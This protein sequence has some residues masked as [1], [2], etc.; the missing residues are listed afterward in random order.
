MVSLNGC[1]WLQQALN[2]APDITG[3]DQY[4]LD[5][6]TLIPEGGTI[7]EGTVVLQGIMSDPDGD[8]VKLQIEL[9]R[10]EEAFTSVPT[11]ESDWVASGVPAAWV[12]TDLANESYKWQYRA[13]DERGEASAWSE[14]GSPGNTDFVVRASTEEPTWVSQPKVLLVICNP[15]LEAD[16]GQTLVQYYGWNDPDLLAQQYI[17]DV[18]QC[19]HGQVQYRIVERFERDE[20]PL[21]TDGF[22][23]TDETYKIAWETRTMH[24]SIIDY[25]Y[26]LKQHDV[27]RKVE[28]GEVDEV[29]IVGFPWGWCWES[30]M[31]GDGAIWINGPEVDYSC[32]RPF[33][34]MGFNYERGVDCMLENLGHRAECV[35]HYVYDGPGWW[36]N[37]DP[38][39]THLWALFTRIDKTHPGEA[40]CGTVHYAPNSD[41]DYDWGN[42]RYVW[43]TC[44]DWLYNFPN[45]TSEKRLV[46]CSEWGNGDMRLH[47]MWWFTHFPHHDSA[48]DGKLNNWWKYVIEWDQYRP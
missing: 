21:F 22:Q 32:S 44:D 19:S 2:R 48:T 38:N 31:A 35:L 24:E 11:W 23:Y 37:R 42:A 17:A 27:R 33:A 12:R 20:W 8:R 4:L 6:S 5:G 36:W 7:T 30:C 43:S 39:A 15:I 14:F 16:G 46:N 9:R 34:I 28:S 18:M 41:T 29:W 26:F 25:I 10:I 1:M 47:H 3:A 40:G 13:V 45:L